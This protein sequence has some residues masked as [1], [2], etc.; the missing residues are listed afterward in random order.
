MSWLTVASPIISILAMVVTIISLIY[1]N[2]RFSKGLKETNKRFDK[3]MLDNLDSKSGWRKKIF[4]IAGNDK[5]DY[6]DLYQLRAAL[7]FTEKKYKHSLSK[8]DKMNIIIIKFCKKLTNE[9]NNIIKEKQ[10]TPNQ[11]E[12]IRLFCRYLLADHWEKNQNKNSKIP[13]DKEEELV[14]YTLL[15][16]LNLIDQ[17]EAKYKNYCFTCLIKKAKKSVM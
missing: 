9:N 11:K 13:E 12:C 8:F 5:I 7:R 17:Y 10:L 4:E 6:N 15:Q 14:K 2:K 1:T 3:T 16:Y